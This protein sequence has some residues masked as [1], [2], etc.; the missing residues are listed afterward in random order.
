MGGQRLGVENGT[1][2]ASALLPGLRLVGGSQLA[3]YLPQHDTARIRP[4]ENPFKAVA[5]HQRPKA[6]E[7]NA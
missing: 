1:G 2:G 4:E 7:G 6:Q 5:V 3:L